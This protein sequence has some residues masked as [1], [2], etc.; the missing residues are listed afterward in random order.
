MQSCPCNCACP[1]AKALLWNHCNYSCQVERR[2]ALE[3]LQ[4]PLSISTVPPRSKSCGCTSYCS[5][6]SSS[7]LQQLQPLSCST[8]QPGERLTAALD[9]AAAN[10]LL[11]YSRLPN[12]RAVHPNLRKW[13]C[14]VTL[15]H[16]E[17]RGAA[18]LY[19][20][21]VTFLLGYSKSQLVATRQSCAR[22]LC[23][24]PCQVALCHLEGKAAASYYSCH[25]R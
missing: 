9:T 25:A 1:L 13:P 19:T 18:A 6:E 22:N 4:F 23:K 16:L 11:C 17:G 15:C 7:R 5:C 10:F 20:A 3:P 12:D 2:L 24:S 21:A 8:L 14:Q